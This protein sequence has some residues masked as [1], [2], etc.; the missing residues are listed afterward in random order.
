[1]GKRLVIGGGGGGSLG[2]GEVGEGEVGEGDGG[3]GGGCGVVSSIVMF[4]ELVASDPLRVSGA[5]SVS[6]GGEADLD[7][8]AAACPLLLAMAAAL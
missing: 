1:M 5:S 8:I 6:P 3:D 7:A 2:A 4:R